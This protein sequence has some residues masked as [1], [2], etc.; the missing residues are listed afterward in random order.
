VFVHGL[1]I[2][3]FLLPVGKRLDGVVQVAGEAAALLV[4]PCPS[5]HPFR[6]HLHTSVPVGDHLREAVA[7]P[8]VLKRSI[9]DKC[10]ELR[11]VPSGGV[12]RPS[13]VV[14]FTRLIHR[15]G[16]AFWQAFGRRRLRRQSQPDLVA[17]ESDAALRRQVSP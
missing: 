14:R 5:Y 11:G 15:R 2:R 13:R 4:S 17:T 8:R 12:E 10:R 6:I 9:L 7:T 16:R 1:L 3:T